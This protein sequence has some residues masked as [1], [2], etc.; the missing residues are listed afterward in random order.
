MKKKKADHSEFNM[1]LLLSVLAI[2]AIFNVKFSYALYSENG[3]FNQ[4]EKAYEIAMEQAEEIRWIARKAIDQSFK[5]GDQIDQ[6]KD[7]IVNMR[8]VEK[9]RPVIMKSFCNRKI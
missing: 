8:I 3:D 6:Y 1:I 2:S 9:N 4:C 5:L 7:M